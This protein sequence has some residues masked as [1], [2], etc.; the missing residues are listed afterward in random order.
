M[1][2]FIIALILVL[3]ILAIIVTL[4][5][6]N[7]LKFKHRLEIRELAKNRK[8]IINDKACN[9]KDS[10]GVDWWK[11]LKE[12]DKTRKLIRPPPIESIELDNKG[13]KH[14]ILYRD[15][16]GNVSYVKDTTIDLGDP[17]KFQP[18]TNT[19]KNILVGQVRKAESRRKKDWK[20][21]LPMYVV[22]FQLL[23]IIIFALAFMEEVAKPFITS[24][25]LQVKQLDLMNELSMRIQDIDS[26]VQRIESNNKYLGNVTS[27]P[28]D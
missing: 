15:G 3:L 27:S 5:I 8:T 19:H 24:K 1:D 21:N 13:K 16:N 2:F 26:G 4:L 7:V 12:K 25:E 9:Y 28:P 14:V 20:D 22:G 10:E 6:M 18:M 11:L 23:I 17:K